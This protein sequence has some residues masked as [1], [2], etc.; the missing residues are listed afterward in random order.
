VMCGEFPGWV[1]VSGSRGGAE[2]LLA[3]LPEALSGEQIG[4][5]LESVDGLQLMISAFGNTVSVD[6]ATLKKTYESGLWGS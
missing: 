3:H 1:V 5:V 6:A 4:S 2:A